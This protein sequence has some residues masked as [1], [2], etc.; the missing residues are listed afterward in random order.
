MLLLT[1]KRGSQ[2]LPPEGEPPALLSSEKVNFIDLLVIF[3]VFHGRRRKHRTEC[4]ILWCWITGATGSRRLLDVLQRGV[5]SFAMR[6]NN[7][8]DQNTVG[9]VRTLAIRR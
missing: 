6:Q 4:G 3:V 2:A 1:V 9:G 5:F 8:V 7:S